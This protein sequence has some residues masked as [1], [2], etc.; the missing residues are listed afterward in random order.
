MSVRI[1]ICLSIYVAA[2]SCLKTRVLETYKSHPCLRKCVDNQPQNCYYDFT[3]EM[4]YTNTKACYDCPMNK[5]DCFRPHCVPADGVPRGILVANR[6]LP[7]PAIN[8]CEGD[9][10]IVNVTN[11]LAGGEGTSVHWHGILQHGSQHMDGVGMVTQCPIPVYTTFEYRFKAENP[12][13]HFWHA[14][15]GLQR[16]DG[17]FGALVVRQS[18]TYE[19]HLG[20]Y[21]KDLPEHTMLV[22]DWLVELS[23]NRFANHHHAGGDNKPRSM[24]INGKGVL[25]EFF[26]NTDNTTKYTPVEIF[27]VTRGLRYRFR[28]ISNGVLNCPIQ[29]SI[30]NHTLTMIATD[31]NA[32]EKIEADSFNIFAGERYDFVLNASMPVGNYWV[33]VRGLAD[34]GVKQ[35]K[36]VA[37]L[38]YTGAPDEDPEGEVTWELADRQGLKV[39]P[40]NKKGTSELIPVAK[41]KSFSDVKDNPALKTN[42]DKKFYL[43]MD[44]NK[45][46]NYH[47]HDVTYYPISAL[48]RPDH[49]YLPQINHV[50]NVLPS[51]PPLSQM[52]DLNEEIFCNH[53]T[54]YG[55]NCSEE[56]CECVFRLQVD[57][58]DTVE[59]VVI[60]EGVTFNAN[61]PMHLHGHK[62]YVVAM[63]KINTST[64]V[65]EVQ[66]LDR[67]GSITR[68]LVDPVAKDTVTVPD[69]GY[70]V[71]RFHADN[72]GMWFFHCHIEF[73]VD[74]GM[75][76]LIQVGDVMPKPPKR[77]PKCGDWS[78]SSH[79]SEDANDDNYDPPVCVGEAPS[80]SKSILAMVLSVVALLLL[81]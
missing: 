10:I 17:L 25:Q 6:M 56:Y 41:L 55:R 81:K 12:G 22:N 76:L 8:V 50:S 2:V 27:H 52:S 46:D 11:N 79:Y 15:S 54:L 72:P 7:G 71:L 77:F 14:H 4:Y 65:E 31:G 62:F 36:Q 35:A 20:L 40:W 53:L 38:R 24:L 66:R 48:E 51:S 47:F 16:T 73:H 58:Y 64:S 21:E 33:R 49:L 1:F 34:C 74:I 39:N 67:T 42:P 13:T 61:H 5:T 30:D 23:I 59:L 69:G 37:I 3:L 44:F 26:D 78:F 57:L 70:S 32:F 63:E 43:A 60:D 68:N 19:P 18:D 9:N 75:G 80:L 29:V 45:I 28:T